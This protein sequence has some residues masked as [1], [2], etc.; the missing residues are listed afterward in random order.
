MW[1]SHIY[2]LY[3][4]IPYS[5]P[6][7]SILSNQFMRISDT[8]IPIFSW[9]YL[10]L[11]VVLVI[12]SA[13]CFFYGK[14]KLAI[15]F[16]LSGGFLIRLYIAGLDP[17]LHYWDERYHALVAKNLI[18]NWL[19]PTLYKKPVL[20]YDYKYW[21][22]NYIWL[23]KQP[24]FLWQM[25]LSMK[26]FGINVIALRMPSV[27]LSTLSIW[28]IYR[29]G[30]LTYN[31]RVGFITA[32]FWALNN[33]TLEFVC[34]Y[35]GSDHNDMAFTC[36]V[37]F[38]IW[39]WTEYVNDKKTYWLLLI[40]LFS[41]VAVLIKWLTGMLVYFIWGASTLIFS[42]E[43][44]TEFKNIAFSVT[45]SCI[46]FLPWQIYI[47]LR[48][49]KEAW[50]EYQYNISHFSKVIEGHY[51]DATYYFNYLPELMGIIQFYFLIPGLIIFLIK[52]NNA[53]YKLS[54]PIIVLSVLL[55]YTLAKTK[56][57]GFI[58]P[59]VPFLLIISAVFFDW[60]I[61]NIIIRI[62]NRH[63][64]IGFS[65]L[66]IIGTA[67][68]NLAPV[69]TMKRQDYN[70]YLWYEGPEHN[71]YYYNMQLY[72]QLPNLLSKKDYVI[73]CAKPQDEASCMFYTG[74]T[75]YSLISAE[76]YKLLRDKCIP[77]ASFP[78]N[79]PDY[80]KTD[81]SVFKIPMAWR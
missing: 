25:A 67:Y 76:N 59:I 38:S 32:V 47:F 54:I 49:P 19:V 37:L 33:Y 43:K 13:F 48:W 40:G 57:H 77:I 22:G 71:S 23:H 10:Y 45:T 51:G 70:G 68:W 15:F 11:G 78:N 21:A 58:M 46:I 80:I 56:M 20:L 18:N 50:Y 64:F 28:A 17:F 75:T 41:G 1:F 34:G 14:K 69:N 4:N 3:D 12:I 60:C 35:F 16:L 29:I 2:A 72:K 74:H 62:K 52:K 61:T 39:A 65:V 6:Y 53:V 36:Y 31:E 26:I 27:V 66:L 81:T 7:I 63:W 5:P 9:F 73:V 79:M 55:F 8:V 24:F 44:I 42:K 30:K